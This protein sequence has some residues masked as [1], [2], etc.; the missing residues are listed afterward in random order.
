MKITVLTENTTSN[1]SLGAEHGLSLFIETKKH[2]ILFDMGQSGLFSENAEKL[3]IDLSAVDIA[4]LSHGHY[5]HGGGMEKFLVLNHKAPVY[6]SR[7]AFEPHYNGTEKYIGLDVSLKDSERLIFTDD[8][9][10]IDDELT[11]FSCN[12]RERARNLG[13]FGLNMLE[14]V[15][16]VPDDFRHEQYLLISEQGR[17]V[18]ISGCSH[19]GVMD[20]TDWFRPDVLVGGFHFSKLP[21][22]EK[23]REYAEFLDSFDTD[24][25]TCHCTGAEQYEYMKSFMKRLSY[26]SVGTTIEIF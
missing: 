20:I 25:Y 10:I 4:V 13:S 3:G 23:L 24:Y 8:K 14:G 16:F 2:K 21:L 17:K 6:L 7:F 1:D 26:I 22:D 9:L 5:D 15:E 19:K 11:L 12:E 18:L